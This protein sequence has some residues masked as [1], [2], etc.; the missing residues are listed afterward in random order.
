MKYLLLVTLLTGCSSVPY[1][2]VGAGYKLEES[3]INWI[4]K[5]GNVKNGNHPISA[6]IDVGFDYQNWSYGISHHSQ[7]FAGV[8]FN[9][10]GEYGK[11]E[12]FV[13]Y[14]YSFK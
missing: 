12:V 13:D 10:D 4:N 3:H 14:K 8:P 2:K 9:N 1:V 7:Y 6:R 5:D 11:T